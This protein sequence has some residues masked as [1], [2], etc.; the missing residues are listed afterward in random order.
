MQAPGA[1]S[2]G[3]GGLPWDSPYRLSARLTV[4]ANRVSAV[5]LLSTLIGQ[6]CAGVPLVALTGAEYDLLLRTAVQQVGLT[7]PRVPVVL[8]V[9]DTIGRSVI[10]PAQIPAG[11]VVA[12]IAL[13][14]LPLL[15]DFG[16][17]VAMNV[18]VALLLSE[19]AG[20]E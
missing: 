6:A 7:Q 9:A 4:G 18:T 19:S 17:I 10:A 5:E 16:I 3:H 11:L 13:S 1:K 20:P 12:V 8:S 15:R 14:S 2:T